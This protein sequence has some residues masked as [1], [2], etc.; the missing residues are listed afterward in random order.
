MIYHGVDFIYVILD[1]QQQ[2]FQLTFQRRM[3]CGL[4][5]ST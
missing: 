3:F 5:A 2:F 1:L 4:D